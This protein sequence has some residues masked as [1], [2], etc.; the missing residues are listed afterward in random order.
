LDIS[1]EENEMMNQSGYISIAN[2]S[3]DYDFSGQF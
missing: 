1:G 3:Q 2:L